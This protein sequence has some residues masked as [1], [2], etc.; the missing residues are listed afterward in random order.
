MTRVLFWLVVV[1]VM[2]VAPALAQSA[3]PEVKASRLGSGAL[4]KLQAGELFLTQTLSKTA[5][6]L[7]LALGE[8]Q[9]QFSADLDGRVTVARGVERRTFAVRGAT[10]DDQTAFNALLAGSPAFRA[11]E[12]LLGSD[13]AYTSPLRPVFMAPREVIR[14]LQGDVDGVLELAAATRPVA[15]ASIVRARQRL[16]PAQCWDTYSRDVIYFT[17]EL[18]SCLSNVSAQW[19]NP[20]ATA[21]CAYEYNLKSSLSAVWLL[22]CYGVM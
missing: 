19:W 16:S 8:D 3:D 6:R 14:V 15:N 5:V 22:D 13:W 11:Y 4:V 2:T 20:F 7:E 18:Q 10:R 12:S 17:Y 9:V 21:W 1:L